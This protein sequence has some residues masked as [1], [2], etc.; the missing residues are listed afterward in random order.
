MS[1]LNGDKSRFNRL[2]KAK[3][4]LRER[5]RDLRIYAD[6]QLSHSPATNDKR[7]KKAA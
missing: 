6:K 5:N 4:H 3:I 1:E 7:K 2:R